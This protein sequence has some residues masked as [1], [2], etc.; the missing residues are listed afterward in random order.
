M[1]VYA[2]RYNQIRGGTIRN[3]IIG[4]YKIRLC[5][6]QRKKETDIN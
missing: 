3:D 4:Y 1:S 6:K 2:M 5:Q